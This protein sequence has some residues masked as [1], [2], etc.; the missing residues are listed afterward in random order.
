MVTAHTDRTV[1]SCVAL[2]RASTGNPVALHATG[3]LQVEIADCRMA[4]G[5]WPADA[6]ELKRSAASLVSVSSH[7]GA[8]LADGGGEW[9]IAKGD[10]LRTSIPSLHGRLRFPIE[11]GSR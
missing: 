10:C 2:I 8:L 9:Q 11:A 4:A 5:L 7:R 1:A 3:G 6:T